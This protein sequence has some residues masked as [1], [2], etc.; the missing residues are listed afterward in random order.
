M[1]YLSHW[2]L[3]RSPFSQ[4]GNKRG[5]FTGGTVEEALARCEFLANQRNQLGMIIGPSGV[6]KTTVLEHFATKRN[7]NSPKELIVRV[8]LRSVTE[9]SIATRLA[10]ALGLDAHSNEE[11]CWNSVQDYLFSRSAIG[12]RTVLMLD[13]LL[14]L[15]DQLTPA[16]S[17][18]WSSQSLWSTLLSVDDEAMVSLP[19]WLLDQCDLK[20]E[21]PPWDLGQTADYFEFALAQAGC[22]D[23]LF[24]A[25]AI[26]RIQEL[27]EGIPRRI[28]Q[29]A[30]LALVAG[31]VRRSDCIGAD[32]V[33]QVCEEFIVSVG[34]K[35]SSFWSE[36]QLNAG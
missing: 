22:T 14:E 36:P 30:G 15:N 16:L 29:I 17:K 12:H 34:T 35:F 28:N 3:K 26:T 11:S 8:D 24:N 33:D 20:I 25:Q 6:G 4:L 1:T 23:A 21:L 13:N 18:L 7:A 2:N 5:A 32:L 27:S 9:L 19:R 31:A 10:S